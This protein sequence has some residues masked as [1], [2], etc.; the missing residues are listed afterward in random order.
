MQLVVG[1]ELDW[2]IFGS[3]LQHICSSFSKDISRLL[4][5]LLKF[6]YLS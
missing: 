5:Q 3:L 4:G 6:L 2:F 1:S